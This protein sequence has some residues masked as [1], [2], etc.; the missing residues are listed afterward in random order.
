MQTIGK[1][2]ELNDIH[3][4]PIAN[5][6][7]RVRIAASGVC[8]SDLSQATGALP[9]GTSTVLGHE[10]ARVVEDVGSEVHHV[11]VGDYVVIAWIAACGHCWFCTQGEVHLC[12]NAIPD[13]YST[14]YAIDVAGTSLFTSMG[15]ASRA[16]PGHF[17]SATEPGRRSRVRGRSR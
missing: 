16:A 12:R 8:H 11:K 17:R 2:L 9:A 1:P 6:Q 7:V 4:A 14:P 15:A 13:S 10:G 5:D 3:L